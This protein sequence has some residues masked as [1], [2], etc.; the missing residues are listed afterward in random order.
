MKTASHEKLLAEISAWNRQHP[1]GTAVNSQLYPGRV[2]KTRTEAMTLF[3]QKAVIYLE[4]FNG[5]FDLVE[6]VPVNEAASGT[7]LTAA[8]AAVPAPAA[9]AAAAPAV[10]AP[11]P[12]TPAAALP[13][14][15]ADAGKRIALLFPG[16]GAQSKGMG[17]T[18]F[19]AYPE[20]TRKASE[21]LGYSIET[22]CLDDPQDQLNQTQFT[23][24]ALYVVGALGYFQR[25]DAN[26]PSARPDYCMGHSLGEYNA[27]L[28]AGVFD[29]ETGL[30]LVIKRGQLM[31]SASGGAMAAVVRV[32]SARI[33]QVLEANGLDAIDLANFNTPTQTVI[34]GPA[35]TMARAVEIFGKEKILA[36]PLKVS[37][38]FHS[39]Y[40]RDAQ[41]DFAAF[42]KDFNLQAPRVTVIANA[43]ARPYEADSIADTLSAQIASPVL[44]TASVNKVLDAGEVEFVEIG[45]S[46]LTKMVKEIRAA[47]NS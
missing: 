32:G 8:S 26:D 47:A 15:S 35:D 27:L 44:W 36:M 13:G 40:M 16:Q 42:L 24:P 21:I 22:L 34:S 4:G 38:A 11:A 39:R 25:R 18:L 31:A 9:P 33:Q 29:F 14:V 20:E 2:L 1:V 3:D 37:A 43:T 12:L 28:A 46:I 45:S 41:Q 19:E 17:K 7:R 6:V 23:Q 30:R 5:Y 10:A